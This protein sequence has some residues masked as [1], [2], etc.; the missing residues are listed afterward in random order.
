[1][2]MPDAIVAVAAVNFP[3]PRRA[4]AQMEGRVLAVVLKH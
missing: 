3:S 2:W 1:M 4:I